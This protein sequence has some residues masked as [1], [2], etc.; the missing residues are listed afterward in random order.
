MA[1]RHLN[2]SDTKD[3]TLIQN[4]VEEFMQEHLPSCEESYQFLMVEYLDGDIGTVYGLNTLSDDA[5][6]YKIKN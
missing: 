5:H 4:G 3:Y 2:R 6:L 1:L